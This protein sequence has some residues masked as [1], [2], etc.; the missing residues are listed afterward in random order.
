MNKFSCETKAS[1]GKYHLTF[2]KNLFNNIIE[3]K[4]EVFTIEKASTD[5]LG[6]KDAG[7]HLSCDKK[8]SP[9]ERDKRRAAA[10]TYF[11]LYIL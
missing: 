6:I 7:K 11:S 5:N 2:L 10:K 8:F 1:L 3:N 9:I 4:K